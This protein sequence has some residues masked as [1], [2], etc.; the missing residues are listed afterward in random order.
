M[1]ACRAAAGKLTERLSR[2][3]LRPHEPAGRRRGSALAERDERARRLFEQQDTL[4]PETVSG[5]RVSDESKRAQAGRLTS[6]IFSTS[7][8]SHAAPISRGGSPPM[9]CE[10]RVSHTAYHVGGAGSPRCTGSV[11]STASLCE[12]SR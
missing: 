3:V 10:Y 6:L 12:R 4:S 8:A 2:R 11:G 1:G 9:A 7:S 5:D